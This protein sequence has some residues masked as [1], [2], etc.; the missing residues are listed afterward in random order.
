MSIHWAWP[1]ITYAIVAALCMLWA[2]ANHGE[3]RTGNH[4]FAL[5]LVCWAL[6]QIVFFYGGFWTEVRP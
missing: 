1:Q 4:N 3:P 6:F 2:A 5:Y